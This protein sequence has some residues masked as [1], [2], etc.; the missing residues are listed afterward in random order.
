MGRLIPSGKGRFFPI[1]PEQGPWLIWSHKW[2]MWHAR[3]STGGA[4]GYTYDLTKAGIFEF[5]TANAYHDRPP[6]RTNSAVPASKAIEDLNR[7]AD[8]MTQDAERIYDLVASLRTTGRTALSTGE[9]PPS[10]QTE[11]NR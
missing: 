10:S 6:F 5:E 4:A 11:K 9:Q 2:G 3:S 8:K 7:R 1:K